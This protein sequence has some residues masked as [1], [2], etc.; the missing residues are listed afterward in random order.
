METDEQSAPTLN[1]PVMENNECESSDLTAV[2]NHQLVEP[3]T[4]TDD[5]HQSIIAETENNSVGAVDEMVDNEEGSMNVVPAG[6][7]DFST[8][9]MSEAD[10]STMTSSSN[11]E[12]TVENDRETI[13]ESTKTISAPER[14]V[15]DGIDAKPIPEPDAQNPSQNEKLSTDKTCTADDGSVAAMADDGSV[16]AMA[17]DGSDAAMADGGSV[18]A[19]AGG[20]SVAAIADAAATAGNND[21]KQQQTSNFKPYPM[22]GI[23]HIKNMTFNSKKLP[24][25]TQ[26]ENGP[27]PLL[28]IMN[29]LL[30]KE[31]IKLPAMMEII[32]SEQL[33]EYLGDYVFE[34][35]PK[36][37]SEDAQLNFEQNM[38]DAMAV[39]HKLQTGLD[40]NVKFNGISSF[41]Y[42]S[43]HIIFDLLSIPMYH[44]WLVD[45]QSPEVVCAVGNCS[46]NQLVEKIINQK[47]S[48]DEDLVSEALIAENYLERTASQLTYHGLAELVITVKEGEMCV[49]F[50]NNHFSTLYKHKNELFTLV[51]D[52]GFLNESE[53][54]WETLSNV[55]GDGL[56]VN[57]EFRTYQK[58]ESSNIPVIPMDS[59]V[60]PQQQI[61]QD[62]LVALSLQDE[63]NRYQATAAT[64]GSASSASSGGSGGSGAGGI[65][66]LP[67]TLSDHELAVQL[68]EEENRQAAAA[69]QQQ[70]MSL[71]QPQQQQQTAAGRSPATAASTNETADGAK[72][73]SDCRIL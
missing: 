20:G 32:T 17:D 29:I 26:N 19:M 24:I 63:A 7:A 2:K 12:M 3:G 65:Q 70:Q 71:Q 27:C 43:E 9:A 69:R 41:E 58:P 42:T 52:Q 34:Q 60:S 61:D 28:A 15:S 11:V 67:N 47:T 46:Y 51:T 39:F 37:I 50:R 54:V 68:Q 6:N 53:V 14:V 62:Y 57:S 66:Q 4:T 73:E 35:I 25:I 64:G 31:K 30:L 38:H 72:K 23:Y 49:L 59:L 44:G 22:P 56:F 5:G 21:E 48:D 33:M 36:N 10:V 40:V 8:A 16:A 45:P 13:V 18:A 55:E 1:V